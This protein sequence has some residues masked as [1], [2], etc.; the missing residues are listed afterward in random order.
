MGNIFNKISKLERSSF[1]I[2]DVV[3]RLGPIARTDIARVT[4]LSHPVVSMLTRELLQMGFLKEDGLDASR[5]GRKPILL[6]ISPGALYV[7]GVDI[8]VTKTRVAVVDLEAKIVKSRTIPTNPEIG[9]E[10]TIHR[11]TRMIREL[12]EESDLSWDKI[13]G[14]GVGIS[15]IVN[16]EKGTCLFWP[17]VEGWENVPLAEILEDEF[18]IPVMV[19]DSARTMALAEY[20][21][22][23]AKDVENFIFVNVGVGVGA[24]I[25]FHGQLYRGTTGTAGE[26]GHT[27]VDEKGPRCKCGNYGC[28]ET[29]VSGPAIVRRAKEALKEGVIS[30]IDKLVGGDHQKITPEIVVEAARRGDKLAFNLM[31]KTGEYLGIAIANAINLFNPQLVVVGAGV[32]RA[33]NLILE[34]L[35]RT[36][37]ARA[38]ESAS[39]NVKIVISEL[40]DE[41]G[42]LGAAI[43]ILKKVFEVS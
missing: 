43:L 31:E 20:W 38:L 21:C 35:K 22:G 25:F 40:P 26:L 18:D 32:S 19:D 3:R 16:H 24:A 7:V 1:L 30:Q 39:R 41:I 17:N 11:L 28:L 9:K 33:G 42:A 13:E 27:T 23:A 4:G 12:V 15:A 14:M 5:G 2:T 34:P 37:R 36:V 6:R 8:G 29:L 10:I